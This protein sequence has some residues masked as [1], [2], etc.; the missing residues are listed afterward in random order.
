MGTLVLANKNGPGRC[1]RARPGPAIR[2]L[3]QEMTMA[4]RSHQPTPE[5]QR[6]GNDLPQR[7]PVPA[8]RPEETRP[9]RSSAGKR[10]Q[11]A[12]RDITRKAGGT[13]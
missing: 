11:H 12:K 6:G 5:H 4:D 10:R 8:P 9:R 13:S 3:Y 7:H 1:V 2:L